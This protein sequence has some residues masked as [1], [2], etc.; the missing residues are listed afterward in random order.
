MVGLV[1]YLR[2]EP[3]DKTHFTAYPYPRKR[4]PHAHTHAHMQHEFSATK[5]IPIHLFSVTTCMYKHYCVPDF[6]S[7]DTE[8]NSAGSLHSQR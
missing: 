7:E 5:S 8:K 1:R 6:V 4:M 3:K 2:K